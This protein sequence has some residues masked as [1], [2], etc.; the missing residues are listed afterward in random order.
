M[1][2]AFTCVGWQVTLCD[3]IREVTSHSSVI[4]VLLTAIYACN[5]FTLLV[6]VWV[7]EIDWLIVLHASKTVDF[8]EPIRRSMDVGR[9]RRRDD[10]RSKNWSRNRRRTR[11]RRRRRDRRLEDEKTS[12][13]TKTTTSPAWRNWSHCQC[14]QDS[15]HQHWPTTVYGSHHL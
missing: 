14:Q 3:L 7:L 4:W 2:R 1:R 13:T 10:R 12:W 15:C 8:T 6:A 5:L 9:G 11:T